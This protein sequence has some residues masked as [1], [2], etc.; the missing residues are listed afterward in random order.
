MKQCT[1]FLHDEVHPAAREL[2]QKYVNVIGDWEKIGQSDAILVRKIHL[3]KDVFDICPRLKVIGFHGSGI[4]GIDL[5]QAQKHGVDVFAVPGLNAQSVAEMNTA[6]ALDLAHRVTE[7]SHR[8]K[9][10]SSMEDALVRYR[11]TEL[12]GKIAG[13]VGLGAV[14][15]RTATILK[16]GFHMPVY[17]Y[18]HGLTAQWACQQGVRWCATLTELLQKADYVFLSL[19]LTPKTT[20]LIDEKELTLMKPTAVLINGARGKLVRESALY[21]ALRDGR[22]AAAASDVFE[23]EPVSPE[24][25]ILQLDNF[26]GTPHLGGNTEEALY[27]VGVGVADGILK[28]LG[29]KA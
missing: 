23:N 12:T 25:P 28:R 26:L 27:Q 15:R 11:G 21:A 8:L 3:E 9:C 1:V 19:P 18:S 22:L 20:Y 17:A 7:S 10:G 4:N 24:E 6:L 5:E 2:L 13:I 14:G 29:V 16:N